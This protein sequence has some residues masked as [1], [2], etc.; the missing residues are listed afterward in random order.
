MTTKKE[1]IIKSVLNEAGRLASDPLTVKQLDTLK[2]FTE[3]RLDTHG[4]HGYM[5]QVSAC[6]KKQF[7]AVD[8][9]KTV[10]TYVLNNNHIKII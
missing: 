6:Y 3:K 8:N 7:I 5:F 4:K 10:A 2:K 9:I 1:K